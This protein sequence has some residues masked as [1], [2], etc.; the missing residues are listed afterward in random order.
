MPVVHCHPPVTNLYGHLY[1]FHYTLANE[2]RCCYSNS[3]AQDMHSHLL[4]QHQPS[5]TD[6]VLLHAGLWAASERLAG[7]D[8]CKECD[9]TASCT[10]FAAFNPAQPAAGHSLSAA[11]TYG[12]AAAHKPPAGAQLQEQQRQTAAELPANLIALHLLLNQYTAGQG[13]TVASRI[14]PASQKAVQPV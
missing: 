1:A 8:C 11:R 6:H 13:P 9:E 12:K 5:V 14:M 4:G 2:E 10:N 7:V 3:R